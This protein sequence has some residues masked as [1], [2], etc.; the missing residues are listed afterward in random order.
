MSDEHLA[1][2]PTP[3]SE[4]PQLL[5]GGVD[6]DALHTDPAD[7]GLGRDLSP[8]DNPAVDDVLPEE[9]AEA[10]DKTQEPDGSDDEE[11]GTTESPSAG[12]EAEDGSPE[13]P[14]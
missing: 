5:P 10:D 3:A 13:P 14:A 12:Q 6:A 2:M 8:D 9:V 7:D 4:D 1:P 11:S